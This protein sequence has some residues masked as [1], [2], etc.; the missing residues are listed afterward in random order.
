MSALDPLDPR[1]RVVTAAAGSGKTTLLV[2]RYLRHLDTTSVERIVAITFTR[3]AAAEL[4]DRVAAAL[5]ARL[6]PESA[7]ESTRS[8]LLPYAPNEE[9]ARKAL[10]A[11]PTAPVGTVDSFVLALLDEFLLDARLPLGDGTDAWL[12]GPLEPGGDPGPAYRAGARATLEALDSDARVVL[13]EQTLGAAISDVATLAK[14]GLVPTAHVRSLTDALGAAFLS[15]ASVSPSQ[16]ADG[17]PAGVSGRLQSQVSPWLSDPTGQPVPLALPAWLAHATDSD[18]KRARTEIAARAA[19]SAGLPEPGSSIW[20]GGYHGWKTLDWFDNSLADRAD[21]LLAA[22]GRLAK[23]ARASA[24][25]EIA[26]TGQL[27]YDELLLAATRLCADPPAALANRFDVLMVDELQ[28]T[29]PR[30]LDFYKAFEAMPRAERSPIAG[31]FVGDARQSIYRFRDADPF[32]WRYFVTQAREQGTWASQQINFRS[33]RLLVDLQQAA[34]AKLDEAGERGVDRLDDLRAAE[35][36]PEGD[37]PDSPR[38]EPVLVVDCPRSSSTD[39]AC[40]AAF[41]ERLHARW[42]THGDETAAVL[43][44]TWSVGEKAVRTLGLLGIDAQLEGDRSLLKTRAAA[45]LRLWLR[46]LLDTSDD[47]ALAGVLKHPSVGLTDRGL[48]LLRRGGGLTSIFAPDAPLDAL[49]EAD[50]DVLLPL[51]PALAAGRWRIGREPTADV[52]EW[53][54]A[55]FRWRA[56]LAAGPESR[57]GRALAELDVLLEVVRTAEQDRVDPGAVLRKITPRDDNGGDDFPI[58]RLH[59]AA[60]VVAVTTHYKAKGLEWDHVALLRVD[61]GRGSSGTTSGE[62]IVAGRSLGAPVIGARLDPAGGLHPSR[63]PVSRLVGTLGRAEAAQESLRVFYVGL[64]RART[65]VTFAL[66]KHDNIG[67]GLQVKR[68]RE[69]FVGSLGGTAAVGVVDPSDLAAPGVAGS[70]RPR[71]RRLAPFEATWGE[72]KGWKLSSPSSRRV[73]GLAAQMRKQ[74]RV[75][76]G[77]AAPAPP[78]DGVLAGVDERVRGDVVHGWLERWAFQGAPEVGAAEA[79]M[80]ERWTAA[81]PA[82]ARW[83]VDLGLALRDGLPGL[84]ELLDSA[85]A[86]HFEWP[87]VGAWDDELVAGRADLVV[88]LPG[89]EA[90]VID[91]KAGSRFATST[92]EVPNLSSYAGQLDA[93]ARALEGAGFR[94]SEVGLMYVRGPSWARFPRGV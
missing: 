35:G 11:L 36:A 37:L 58:I 80:K 89:R 49:D 4:K 93:Y 21:E 3:K 68:L 16:W 77:P 25:R 31:F 5:H 40:L 28:D 92:S 53:L 7:T 51:L 52:L 79:Y 67:N 17:P 41:A 70:L 56:L 85:T 47:I 27:G 59:R 43:V 64:T 33:S 13:A 60:K 76:M 6:D 26:R 12:D 72:A 88:E 94:V 63:G 1:T 10:A 86:L 14:S 46:A 34:F 82:V 22:F 69:V 83:L 48:L 38:V 74:A 90:V 39:G 54:A 18:L 57:G 2:R 84:S 32:G 65:S 73:D 42:E 23:T 50:R 61:G 78:E 8:L 55:T 71:T 20:W 19:A 87:M 9:T 62:A 24:L 81:D 44:P 91:F 29:N 30:Q 15:H 66:G 45:D 75:V